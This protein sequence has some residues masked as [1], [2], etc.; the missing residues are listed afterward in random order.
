VYRESG[1]YSTYSA[2]L[3]RW[4][5][6]AHVDADRGR[7]HASYSAQWL[8]GYRECGSLADLEGT[9]CRA[10]GS[11]LYH[12]VDAAVRFGSTVTANAGVS[13]LTNRI[14]PFLNFGTDA[15]TDTSTYRLLGRTYFLSL[16]YTMR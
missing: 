8:G 2:A 11:V 12:D 4:R 7:W 14:P 16:R 3:P 6:L 9:Y 10:V 1:T 5:S 13:N 15:N